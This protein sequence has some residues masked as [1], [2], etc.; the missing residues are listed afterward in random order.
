MILRVFLVESSVLG[1]SARMER[2]LILRFMTASSKQVTG[3][4]VFGLIRA[5]ETSRLLAK[6]R[7]SSVPLNVE[8]T[9]LVS[10]PFGDG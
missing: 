7:F 3:K 6:Y 1:D 10:F 2:D 9:Q 8:Q 4:V 5:S